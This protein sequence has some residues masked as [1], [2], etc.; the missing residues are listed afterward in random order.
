MK[1]TKEDLIEKGAWYGLLNWFQEKGLEKVDWSEITE[2]KSEPGTDFEYMVWMCKTF[3]ISLKVINQKSRFWQRREYRN[4]NLTNLEDS[5]GFW[6]R[7]EYDKNGRRTY[8]E[9]SDGFKKSS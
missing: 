7:Y 8:Y 1:I 9:N 2:F 6:S 4:G 5:K 3:K